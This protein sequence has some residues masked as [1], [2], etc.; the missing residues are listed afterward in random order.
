MDTDCKVIPSSQLWRSGA[1]N[2]HPHPQCLRVSCT[3]LPLW[4]PYPFKR[5]FICSAT[6]AGNH[7]FIPRFALSLSLHI[8]LVSSEYSFKQNLLNC[9]L[10]SHSC[11]CIIA[12]FSHPVACFSNH[13]CCSL[14]LYFQS[15]GF[16]SC[17]YCFWRR[18]WQPIPVFLP[19]EFHGQRSLVGYSPWGHKES[20]TTEWLTLSL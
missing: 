11:S 7:S 19:G 4:L 6:W 15:S 12:A 13:F 10:H 16:M 2:S 9:S 20:D 1:P 17:Y 5:H 8:P 14:I 18:K 3:C